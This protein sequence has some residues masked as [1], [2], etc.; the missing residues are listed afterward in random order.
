MQLTN[1]SHS[2]FSSGPE[3]HQINDRIETVLSDAEKLLSLE[4]RKWG[5]SVLTGLG[6]TLFGS[7]EITCAVVYALFKFL[8]IIVDRCAYGQDEALLAY[9]ECIRALIYIPHGIGNIGRGALEILQLCAL[10]RAR[11][12]F[13][14]YPT[15]ISSVLLVPDMGE[16]QYLVETQL[17][18]SSRLPESSL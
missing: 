7:V 2:R 14:P 17:D 10:T 11:L 9:R 1:P 5:I 13:F 16:N 6:R 12:Q 4:G 3:N 15:Q 8:E 18:G